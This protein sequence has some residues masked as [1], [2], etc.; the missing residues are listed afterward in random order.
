[1]KIKVNYFLDLFLLIENI[2]VSLI[3]YGC[4]YFCD[5]RKK[6]T[7]EMLEDIKKDSKAFLAEIKIEEE[8]EKEG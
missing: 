2:L 8:K 6:N 7:S 1:M 4:S 3:L 5:C